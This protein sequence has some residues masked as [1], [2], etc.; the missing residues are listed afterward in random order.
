MRVH[1]SP[2]RPQYS[3]LSLHQTDSSDPAMGTQSGYTN[4]R[5]SRRFDLHSNQ[6]SPGSS[7]YSNGSQQT[8]VTRLDNQFGQIGAHTN[9]TVGTSGFQFG[10]S[11]NGSSSTNSKDPGFKEIITTGSTTASA[12]AETDP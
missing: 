1:N 8:S 5:I 4:Q 10:H 11:S 9:S 6:L 7:A 12:D 3:T 2:L